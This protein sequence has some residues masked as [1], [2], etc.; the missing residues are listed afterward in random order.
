MGCSGLNSHL[1]YLLHTKD[2]PICKFGYMN[3]SPK[4]YFLFCSLYAIQWTKLI[5]SVES[6]ADFNIRNL[7]FWDKSLNDAQNKEIFKAVHTFIFETKRFVWLQL[8][9]ICIKNFINV[10]IVKYL[11]MVF[12]IN[13][14]QTNHIGNQKW[15]IYVTLL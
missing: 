4:R 2:S 5:N 7:V 13:L 8:D 6:V 14:C 11:K 10:I 12:S 15:V 1:H 3:E 9:M